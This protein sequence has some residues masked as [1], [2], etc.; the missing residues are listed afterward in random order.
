MFDLNLQSIMYPKAIILLLATS[1]V[2]AWLLYYCYTLKLKNEKILGTYHAAYIA[3]S[4]CITLWISSNAYFHTDLLVEFGDA[5]GIFMAKLANLASFFAFAFAFYFSCRLS[6]AKEKRQVFKWQFIVFYGLS[7]YSLYVNLQPN[8]T[9]KN[10]A[11]VAPSDFIIDFG[12]QTSVFFMS[13]I[14]LVVLTLTNLIAMRRRSS[15]LSLTKNNYMIAGI[16]VFMLSTAT[17]HLGMTYFLGDF[18]LT[19]LPPAF[20]IS[21]M[22]LMGY[23][24]LTSRFY[25]IKYLFFL[26]LTVAVT[27]VLYLVPLSLV[28]DFTAYQFELIVAYS[29]ILGLTWQKLL[30]RVKKYTSLMVYNSP[31]PPTEQI[32]SLVEEFQ[33]SPTT[34]IQKLATLLNVPGNKMQLVKNSHDSDVYTH[35]LAKIR[36]PLVFEEITDK[37][38]N[39]TGQDTLAALHYKMSQNEAAVVMPLFDSQQMISHLLISPH[40]QD[41]RLFSN[42]ELVVLEKVLKQAQGY[43]NFERRICQSQALANSIA[44][45]MRNPLTQLQLN[46]ETLQIQVQTQADLKTLLDQI[47]KGKMAIDRGRQL[48]NIILREVNNSSLD[49]EP[50]TTSPIKRLLMQALNQYGFESEQIE[51]RVHLNINEDFSVR[52]NDTLFNFVIFNLCRNSIY[53]FDSYPESRIEITSCSNGHEN[54]VVFRDTG[55]GIPEN[56]RTRIFDDFFSYNKNGGSGLGLGYCLRVMNSFGGRIQCK[57]KHGEYTEFHLIFPILSVESSIYDEVVNH[58]SV[59]DAVQRQPGS[60]ANQPLSTPATG[61]YGG[62]TILIVDDQ[63]VQRALIK[64]Y[65]EQLGIDTIQANNGKIA[66]DIFQNNPIDLV[67]MDIQMPVMN[68]FDAA[69]KIKQLS[70]AT[71]V[72]ALSGESGSRELEIISNMMD[73]YLTKPASKPALTAMLNQWLTEKSPVSC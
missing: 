51:S 22:L 70:P 31:M 46:L 24:S 5:G 23:A 9:V 48:I 36:E 65:L 56:I 54:R 44:H 20:S 62:K 1:M 37:L 28:M 60:V 2:M 68:G 64:L 57:S 35:Y 32:Y 67:L 12:P 30:N 45:E 39:S 18:S 25:S 4:S 33:S 14:T 71:P 34:A 8:L 15:K 10:V 47:E 49:Q 3:Y 16:V 69:A 6:A 55:P 52:V 11:I 53:Y 63:E 13:L 27:S 19:W 73:G 7:F 21:E 29:V 42:E 40:K 17:I 59:I 41:G 66:V 50:M 72:I 26:A 61:D 38:D 58:S 43:I